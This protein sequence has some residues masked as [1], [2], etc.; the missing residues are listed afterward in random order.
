[1]SFILFC[2]LAIKTK[3]IS[4]L[5]HHLFCHYPLRELYS[6]ILL[7][8]YSL[9]GTELMSS[10]IQHH[11][12]RLE[13]FL[14]FTFFFYRFWSSFSFLNPLYHHNVDYLSFHFI[15][16]V[17]QLF[18][19][20]L[21]CYLQ[22]SSSAF[23]MS[24]FQSPLLFALFSLFSTQAAILSLLISFIDSCNLFV[25]QYQ[26]SESRDIMISPI[27][28]SILSMV[29]AILSLASWMPTNTIFPYI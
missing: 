14:H 25:L 12:E 11:L 4:T 8:L 10:F 5:W 16:S 3:L 13:P 28:S 29:P 22:G 24:C 17:V 19:N 26:R 2:S 27:S 9:F 1:M 18:S 20:P 7:T 23:C 21:R 6:I 15:C